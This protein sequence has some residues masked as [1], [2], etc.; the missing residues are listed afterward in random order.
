MIR[1][2]ADDVLPR[3]VLVP[4]LAV[5]RYSVCGFTDDFEHPGEGKLQYAIGI[6][7]PARVAPHHRHSGGASFFEPLFDALNRAGVRDV[8]VGGFA[9]VLRGQAWLTADIELVIDLVPDEASSR[10]RRNGF[11]HSRIVVDNQ[12]ELARHRRW[13]SAQRRV[14][15]LT[16]FGCKEARAGTIERLAPRPT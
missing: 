14:F 16:F 11:P 8:V 4:C 13:T 15:G 12:D 5:L 1:L 10:I 2:R 6:D 7:V 9:T 3:D